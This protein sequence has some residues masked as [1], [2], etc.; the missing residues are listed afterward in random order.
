MEP[1]MMKR[2]DVE[3]MLIYIRSGLIHQHQET[4]RSDLIAIFEAALAV[5]D[6]KHSGKYVF[7]NFGEGDRYHDLWHQYGDLIREICFRYETM[8]QGGRP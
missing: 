5:A 4:N 8:R 1:Y 3:V 7:V 6:P 2:A